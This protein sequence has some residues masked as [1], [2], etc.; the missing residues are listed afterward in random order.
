MQDPSGPQSSTMPSMHLSAV[1]PYLGFDK[2]DMVILSALLY[3]NIY[4][5]LP[6]FHD[7]IV[8]SSQ[9][10]SFSVSRW[11]TSRQRPFLAMLRIQRWSRWVIIRVSSFYLVSVIGNFVSVITKS[12][13]SSFD[14][15]MPIVSIG[16][17]FVRDPDLFGSLNEN[18]LLKGPFLTHASYCAAARPLKHVR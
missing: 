11:Q 17:D 14:P 16:R 6:Y 2:A 1:P 15:S 12:N 8:S 5:A 9:V 18:R 7:K 10:S 13:Q 4:L 3:Q